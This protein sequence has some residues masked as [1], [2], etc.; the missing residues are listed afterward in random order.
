[1]KALLSV[2]AVSFLAA[3]FAAAEPVNKKCPVN[4]SKAANPSKT[5][6]HEG[7]E[8]AFCCGNCKAKFEA[9]PAKYAK[10]IK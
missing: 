9:D 2:L 6:T 4:P 7:K 1:M 8:V 3:G 5:T 10:N